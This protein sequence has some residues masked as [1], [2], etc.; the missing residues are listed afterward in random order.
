MEQDAKRARR[1]FLKVSGAAVAG[2]AFGAGKV[3][4]GEQAVAAA[5]STIVPD[6]AEFDVIVIGAG[7]AG[8]AA[9][10]DAAQRGARTLLLE[11]RNRIGGRTFTTYYEGKKLELGG[12]WIHWS[13][14]FVW[15]EVNRYGLTIDESPG[16]SPDDVSWLVGGRM[17]RAPAAKAFPLLSAGLA[18]YCDADGQ[19]S[20]TIFPRAHDPFFSKTVAK[21]DGLSMQ[22]RLDQV[23]LAP[24][25]RDLVAAFLALDCHNDPRL[26]GAVDQFK[27]WSLGDFDMGLMSDKL[28]RYKIAEGTGALAHAMLGDARLDLLLSTPVQGVRTEGDTSTVTTASGKSFKAR[29]V[30]VTVPMN[31]L[32]TIEFSPALSSAKR[33]ASEEEHVGKG[34]KC[35][36]RIKQKVGNWMGLAPFPH[37]ITA[38]W[39]DRQLEDGT[40]LVCFGPPGKLDINDEES[41]QAALRHLLPGAD[42]VSVTG[43]QWTEDPYARGTWAMYRPNQYTRY[44]GALGEREGN[45]FFASGDSA[46][47]WKGF[48]DG[49]IESGSRAAHQA[50]TRLGIKA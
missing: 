32:K 34:A 40:L 13:Q 38:I 44:L 36:V 47:G 15:A 33:K 43:Y 5:R 41:V 46:H 18:K 31:V 48:I 1:G 49:A 9:A 24:E 42:V 16:F 10:R 8:L 4:A 37:P 27:W 22:D 3:L 26:A 20:R 7:F 19:S 21:Y 35:Y 30:I 11:A 50:I 45:V 17:R 2:A 14:P 29:A 25:Q 28:G 39:T 6:G 12:T 23:R